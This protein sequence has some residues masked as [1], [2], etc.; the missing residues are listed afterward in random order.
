MTIHQQ[1]LNLGQHNVEHFTLT[2][3]HGMQIELMN[4]GASWVDARVADRNGVIESVTLAYDDMSD[5]IANPSFFGCVVGRVAGRIA[6]SRFHLNGQDYAV[7]A[8]SGVHQLHGGANAMWQQPWTVAQ[9]VD[10]ADYTSVR[11]EYISPAGENGYP[12]T[13]TVAVT[14]VLTDDNTVSIM[15]HGVADAPTVCNLTNHAYFNL[16]GNA[17]VDVT[18]HAL[19]VQASKVCVMSDDLIVTGDESAVDGSAF[20][21]R[22]AKPLCDALSSNDPR[23]VRARGVDHYFILDQGLREIPQVVLQDPHSGRRLS[24]WSNQ[25]CVVLYAHNYASG[26]QLRHGAVGTPHDALCIETQKLPHVWASNGDH[27]AAMD[28]NHAYTQR[29]DFRFDVF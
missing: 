26:E 22:I 3:R 19:Q 27:P 18:Q 10:E 4:W 12:A 15:Y 21:F 2:N 14:Y 9:V 29:T 24:V 17:R 16:S 8:N 25:P 5:Y 13:L 6:D 7:T 1:T 23:I 28:A 11:F 20:D